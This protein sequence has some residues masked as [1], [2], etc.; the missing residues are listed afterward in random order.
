LDIDT[1]RGASA[2]AGATLGLGDDEAMATRIVLTYADRWPCRLSAVLQDLAL[3]SFAIE[4]LSP[5]TPAA[6]RGVKLQLSAKCGVPHYW[7]VDPDPRLVEI[8]R[9]AGPAYEPG[10][11]P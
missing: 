2:H 10:T 9:L 11:A 6:D 4:E 1:S 7:I 5:T 3:V 8:H